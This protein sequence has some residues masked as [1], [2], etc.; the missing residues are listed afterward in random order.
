MLALQSFTC[1]LSFNLVFKSLAVHRKVLISSEL[2]CF[3]D[4]KCRPTRELSSS[5][6]ITKSTEWIY[7]VICTNDTPLRITYSLIGIVAIMAYF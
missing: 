5:F 3:S 2:N 7:S 4:K 1:P 6:L